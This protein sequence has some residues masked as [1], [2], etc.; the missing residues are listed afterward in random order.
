VEKIHFFMIFNALEISKQ[1]QTQ[2]ARVVALWTYCLFIFSN[3]VCNKVTVVR[4]EC[5]RKWQDT[6]SSNHIG[7]NKSREYGHT[8]HVTNVTNR[9]RW[10]ISTYAQLSCYTYSHLCQSYTYNGDLLSWIYAQIKC[11]SLDQKWNRRIEISCKA[12]LLSCSYIIKGQKY[13]LSVKFDTSSN[14]LSL[15]LPVCVIRTAHFWTRS[16][17]TNKTFL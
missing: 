9:V 4:F 7:I 1:K 5:V 2:C 8:T 12:V 14:C 10:V 11:S 13:S 16:I 17:C 3:Y 6:F 15:S